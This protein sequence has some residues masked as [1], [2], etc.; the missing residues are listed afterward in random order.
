MIHTNPSVVVE[1]DTDRKALLFEVYAMYFY[2]AVTATVAL[3]TA[4]FLYW[5]TTSTDDRYGDVVGY[6][7]A[8]LCL[9]G[10]LAAGVASAELVT[11]RWRALAGPRLSG[12]AAPTRA[13][14]RAITT[15]YEHEQTKRPAR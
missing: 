6:L 10:V 15:A 7:G 14:D 8:A 11:P 1:N 9:L 12:T 3:L 5:S 4:G 13:M 2:C